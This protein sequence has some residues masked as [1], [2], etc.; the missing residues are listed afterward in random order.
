[1]KGYWKWRVTGQNAVDA[2]PPPKPVRQ[3]CGLCGAFLPNWKDGE[4]ILKC[5][6]CGTESVRDAL[7][8]AHPS[9]VEKC[10]CGHMFHGDGKCAFCDCG[11]SK[12]LPPAPEV[13][14]SKLSAIDPDTG[15]D[16][17]MTPLCAYD[18]K[19][20]L[21]AEAKDAIPPA[22]DASPVKEER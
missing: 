2:L 1:M 4:R 15:S 9:R 21:K 12:A 7:P 10:A 3:Q 16:E 22:P 13:E 5:G 20:L 17:G 6:R 18:T 8:L 11:W 14:D 19:R